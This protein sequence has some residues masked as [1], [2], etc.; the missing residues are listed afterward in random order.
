MVEFECCGLRLLFCVVRYEI[1]SAINLLHT[2]KNNK[3]K[4]ILFFY[5]FFLC[6]FGFTFILKIYSLRFFVI[7]ILFRMTCH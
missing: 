4:F 2:T 7:N 3:T 6:Y 5:Q 1:T